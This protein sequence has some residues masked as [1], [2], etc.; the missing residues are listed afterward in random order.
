MGKV[1]VVSTD[2]D[3]DESHEWL[4]DEGN[5][6]LVGN[7][8]CRLEGTEVDGTTHILVIKGV[9]PS[10]TGGSMVRIG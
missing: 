3:S 9:D 1:R 6:V 10:R 8:P 5:Y 7:D 2:P 4:L